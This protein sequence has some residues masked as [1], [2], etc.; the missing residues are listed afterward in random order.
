[1]KR[2]IFVL[3]LALA[4]GLHRVGGPG[5]QHQ[6]APGVSGC[7]CL[8]PGVSA[9]R[10]RAVVEAPRPPGPGHRRAARRLLRLGRGRR[11]DAVRGAALY[12]EQQQQH[13]DR[14]HRRAQWSIAFAA[15]W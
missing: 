8:L 6:D 1:M 7:A 12:R 10:A 15:G 11:P 3:M 9:R 14:A 4:V 13:G 2:T 5:F